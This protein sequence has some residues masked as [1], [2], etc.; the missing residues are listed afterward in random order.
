MRFA[1][2]LTLCACSVAWAQ[3]TTPPPLLSQEPVPACK[4]YA[5]CAPGL[6]CFA[7][8]CEPSCAT[9]AD[10]GGGQHCI[11]RR[12]VAAGKWARGVC[13]TGRDGEICEG[14]RDCD[15]GLAC[16]GRRP[17]TDGGGFESFCQD[18]RV[19]APPS[20][21]ERF[22]Y[23]GT[24][25][26][27][28]HLVSEPALRMIGGGAAAF[29]G[30]Y[31]TVLFVGLAFGTPLG[32]VP[33]VGPFLVGAKVW[34][35]NASEDMGTVILVALDFIAQAG[36]VVLFSVG[37]ANPNKWLERNPAAT[38]SITLAPGAPGSLLGASLVGRF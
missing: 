30:G 29:L 13:R 15:A 28:F 6:M 34:R 9:S 31:M 2:A 22:V 26:E 3:E 11:G 7:G 20:G 8:V 32:A 25:P 16:T 1:L 17:R 10:C 18:Q 33:I 21:P 37:L 14:P 38:P 23:G 36:G 27:G 4:S 24:V 12:E 19:G 5:D 35:N